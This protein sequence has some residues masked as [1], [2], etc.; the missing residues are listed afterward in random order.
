MLDRLATRA[1]FWSALAIFAAVGG[2]LSVGADYPSALSALGVTI[3]AVQTGGILPSFADAAP[4]LSLAAFAIAIAGWRLLHRAATPLASGHGHKDAHDR[5]RQL[6]IAMHSNAEGV[7]L[8]GAIRDASGAI[9]DFEIRDVNP[10]GTK[11][12]RAGQV[13]LVGRRLRRDFPAAWHEGVFDRYVEAVASHTPLME[14]VRVNRRQFAGGWLYHQAVPTGDGVA[15]TLRDISQRKREE[16]RLRRA[17][18]TD[19]LTRLYNRRGFLTLADQ[20]LR[21]AR[22]QDKDAVLMYVDM[23]EFKELNDQY[24]HAEGDRALAAVGRLLRR[25]VRD[26]D[27]V[28]RLGGDEFTIMALDADRASARIIQ[29]R[30]EERVALLNAS[31]ELAAPLSLTIGHT[32]VRPSDHAPLTE[33]LA[34]ADAL[35]YA[36]KKRRKLT[37]AVAAHTASRGRPRAVPDRGPV[38]APAFV[39]PPDVAA[40]ARATAVAAAARIPSSTGSTGYAPTRVA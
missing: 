19:D 5:V 34:R 31:Q 36:R 12:I 38:A 24:G 6:Q 35:L 30:I 7:F 20:Q 29:R 3:P 28:A 25:S 32:R 2:L 27:V 18:L 4:F 26:C 21:I 16:I 22:R 13:D 8:L 1:L 40:I 15:V 11:M 33:L 10:S 37:A 14:E 17:S 23:D 39:V 9:G